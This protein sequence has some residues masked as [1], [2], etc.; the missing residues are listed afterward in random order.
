MNARRLAIGFASTALL[1][2]I[3]TLIARLAGFGR[4]LVFSP[5]VGAGGVGTAYQS[6]NQLPNVL[7][8]VIAGGALAGAIVPLLAAPLARARTKEASEIASGLI[9]WA[10]TI[11]LPL[12]LLVAAFHAPIGA[13]LVSAGAGADQAPGT[14]ALAGRLLLMFSPQLVLYA[15]G[16]VLTGVLQAHRKFLWPAFM[17]LLSSV[18]VMAAYLAYYIVTD[19]AGPGPGAAGAAAEAWLGWGTTAGVLAISL[20]LLL[21]A[22]RTGI[23]LRPRWTFPPGVAG[24]ALRLGGAGVAALLAQQA[25]VVATLL[26]SNKAGGTGAYVVFSYTQAV[27]LLPYAVLAVPLATVAFP[28]L[29]ELAGAGDDDGF[30]RAA[31]GGLRVVAAAG[32]V[33]VALLVG[34]AAPLQAFFTAMDAEGGSAGVPFPAMAAAI[35]AMSL[36]LPGWALVAYLSRVFYARERSR[37]AALGA[38]AGWAA[39][40]L[41]ALVLVPLLSTW[42]PSFFAWGAGGRPATAGE[43]TLVALTAANALGMIAAG[44]LLLA[45]L[46]A[47]AGAGALK[48]FPRTFGVLAL[49]TA[50]GAAVGAWVGLQM[51]AATAGWAPLAGAVLAGVLGAGAGVLV[52]LGALVLGDRSLL[53]AARALT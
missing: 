35:V 7:F 41:A 5:T 48:G 26:L 9:T 40:V 6:A 14:A 12:S 32:A 15:I 21:P 25:A 11:T 50:L 27:Y 1:V 39:V 43:A 8:E 38:S 2:S 3:V 18:V 46:R 16:A 45:S 34:A 49:G 28:R 33:G 31:A 23:R 13:L 36:G 29:S 22:T 53:R 20:P 19:G 17:P 51:L 42:R 37:H 24:R 4:W 30:G 10:I 44:I 47:V 52:V